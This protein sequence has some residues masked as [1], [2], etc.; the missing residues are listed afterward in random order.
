I[1][2]KEA[3]F[4]DV[5]GET[6]TAANWA[7][8]EGYML[9]TSDNTFSPKRVI[10]RGEVVTV[11]WRMAGKPT[12]PAH[13][14]SDIDQTSDTGKAAAW[15]YSTGIS[16]GTTTTTFEPAKGATRGQAIVMMWRAAGKPQA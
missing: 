14:F 16:Y 12:A 15:A 11:L 7:K 1:T 9:G 8:K 6:A 5:S 10:T 2:P 13:P 3:V 4:T